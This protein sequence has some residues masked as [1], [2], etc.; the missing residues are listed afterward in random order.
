MENESKKNISSGLKVLKIGAEWCPECVIMKPRWKEIEEEFS[1][2]NTEYYEADE[3]K[4]LSKKYNVKD[5]PTF[6]FLDKNGD[7]ILRKEGI[8]SKEDLIKII[9]DL[10]QSGDDKENKDK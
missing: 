4:D 5:V 3:N 9:E 1:W 6:I 7:E 2:L 8:V 10:D